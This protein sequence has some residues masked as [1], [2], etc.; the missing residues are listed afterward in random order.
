MWWCNNT[1]T[2]AKGRVYHSPLGRAEAVESFIDVTNDD[3]PT[4]KVVSWN[5][6]LYTFTQDGIHEIL[7]SGVDGIFTP[8]KIGLY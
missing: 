5:G 6:H 8:R 2:G 4:Q 3:D 1:V 7:G